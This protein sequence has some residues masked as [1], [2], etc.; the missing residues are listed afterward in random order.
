MASN[1]RTY[2]IHHKC[3]SNN[4][5]FDIDNGTDDIL[6]NVHST[7]LFLYDEMSLCESSTGKELIKIHKECFHIHVR[8][9]I[10]AINSNDNTDQNLATVKRI[11][12]QHHSQ[13]T[14]EID[15][16]Y[17]VY[18]VEHI[19]GLFDHEFR[20]TTGNKIVVNLTK[21]VND[22]KEGNMYYV[23]ISD[24]DGGDLFLLALVIALWCAQRWY[25]I[26]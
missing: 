9:H 21:N 5:K 24:D 11:H 23:E 20:L 14:F 4:H 12:D 1:P 3:L 13:I 6:Y 10:S 19:G 7:A 15:S 22:L 8:Y 26:S 17:G 25:H 16:I 2:R 18:K